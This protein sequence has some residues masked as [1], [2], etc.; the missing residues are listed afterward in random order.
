MLYDIN[1]SLPLTLG[2]KVEKP[3]PA[4]PDWKPS[5][6]QP[7]VFTHRHTGLMKFTAPSFAHPVEAQCGK[8]PVV[9]AQPMPQQAP[10]KGHMPPPPPPVDD[11]DDEKP[12]D[13]KVPTPVLNSPRIV[14][15]LVPI[16]CGWYMTSGKHKPTEHDFEWARYWDG[17]RWSQAVGAL[18]NEAIVERKRNCR[19]VYVKETDISWLDGARVT[20]PICQAQNDKAWWVINPA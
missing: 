10:A 9:A 14:C 8:K 3:R 12:K 1:D 13:K 6:T 19:G 16:L 2:S 11:D 5:G 18:A 17:K 20:N 15:G 4:L 7:G